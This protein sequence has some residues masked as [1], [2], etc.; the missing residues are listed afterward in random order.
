VLA[1]VLAPWQKTGGQQM[2]ELTAK[3]AIVVGAGIAGLSAAKALAGHFG[4][5]TIL[6]RDMLPSDAVPRPGTPQSRHVHALLAG[7]LIALEKLFP[8]IETELEQAG[9]V[10]L[11][12][13]QFRMERPG[14]DPYP[15]HEV[16]FSWLSVSR[17]LLECVTR[18]AVQRQENIELLGGCRVGEVV[19]CP[20]G[21]AVTGVRCEMSDGKIETLSA[22]LVVDASGR[23]VL[24][25]AALDS[26]HF[27]R[28][29]ETEIGIDHA[30]STAVFEQPP[31]VC[32]AWK[33]VVV[34]PSAPDSSR[35]AVLALIE[36]GQWI[37]TLA[38][39]HGD[40]PPG[41]IEGFLAFAKTLRTPTIYDAIK[42]ANPV[43]PIVRYML[44]CSTRRHF[45][46]LERFP[47]GLLAIGDAICR[48]NPV[49]AQG[50]SVAVQEAVILDRL[51]SDKAGG[52]HPLDGLAPAF[53]AEIQAVLET[54]WGIATSD[55]IYPRTRGQRP[56][57]LER[58]L[59]FNIALVR[60]G[61]EDASVH[62]LIMEVNH[63]LK[64]QSA[65]HAP[66]I[67]ERVAK[68]LAASG[69][70]AVPEF[71]NLGPFWDVHSMSI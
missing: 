66:E 65:L 2:P 11:A 21:S 56:V 27:P 59:Q 25:L 22:D 42:G 35:G 60:L 64:P 4:R 8:G 14:F 10:R 12:A 34:L 67:A 36:N 16:G 71:C 37:V 48:F 6:E 24:A 9:A 5:V 17:P 52:L 26:T 58:R 18:R 63:L 53:F 23:G 47:R 57:D 55:F 46:N 70:V 19:A 7:G 31:D 61:A 38:G 33:T 69:H 68:L 29:E 40:A 39:N 28:P 43:G 51:L 3:H 20:D 54:P 15:Q 30:Y 41:D 45:E 62:R 50:M 44:P 49:F 13:E 32:S 1:D